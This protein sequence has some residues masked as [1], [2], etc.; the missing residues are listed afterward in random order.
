MILLLAFVGRA[1]AADKVVA[2]FGGLSGFQSATWIAKDLRIFHRYGLDVELVM[3]TGGALSVATLLSG[4]SQFATGSATAPLLA[5]ARG[6]DVTILAAS[7]NKFP[8][9]FVAK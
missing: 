2:D 1:H 7:Y 9:A 6:S 3:I 4:S 5:R 8:Y